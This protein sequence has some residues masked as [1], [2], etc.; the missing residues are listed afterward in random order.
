MFCYSKSVFNSFFLHNFYHDWWICSDVTVFVLIKSFPC[1]YVLYSTKEV[2]YYPCQVRLEIL[3]STRNRGVPPYVS[4]F[5][6]KF[7]QNP[8]FFMKHS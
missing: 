1:C 2:L 7:W 6:I 3:V 4:C 8:N 5:P